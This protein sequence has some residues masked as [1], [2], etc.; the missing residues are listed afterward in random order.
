MP[1]GLTDYGADTFTNWITGVA[2]PPA[3]FW[4]ALCLEQPDE[5]YDGTVLATIEPSGGSYARREIDRG[6]AD[7]SGASEGAVS[8][9]MLT[10]P[11]ATLDWGVITHYA[12]CTASTAGE[13]YGYGELDEAY[14]VLTGGQL[15]LPVGGIG[16]ALRPPS[17]PV[18]L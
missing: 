11:V 13:V 6:V 8:L 16:I 7:W 9:T 3:S 12:L 1:S 4:V 15:F 18:V 5:G 2:T 10:F 14:Q 17:N